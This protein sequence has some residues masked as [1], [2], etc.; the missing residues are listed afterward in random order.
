VLASAGGVTKATVMGEPGNGTGAD[1]GGDG[2]GGGGGGGSAMRASV[3]AVRT[4][5]SGS[6]AIS[7][8]AAAVTRRGGRRYVCYC[9]TLTTH[10]LNHIQTH[11][12]TH[13][14]THLT[15]TELA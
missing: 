10:S 4:G 3:S 15:C 8:P 1:S 12:Y 13:T 7:T 2:G 9:A 14:R 6:G 11:T 5:T